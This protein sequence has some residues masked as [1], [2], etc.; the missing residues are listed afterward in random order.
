MNKEEITVKELA[1]ALLEYGR[2]KHGNE[3]G[4]CFAFGSLEGIFES[5][6]WGLRPLQEVVNSAYYRTQ[7]DLEE[8]Q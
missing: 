1:K 8:L 3:L 7:K 4:Y 6:R 5:A 2:K